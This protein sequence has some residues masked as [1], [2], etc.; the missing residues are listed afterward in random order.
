MAA[1]CR[2]GRLC[3]S[4]LEAWLRSVA[5]QSKKL[6]AYFKATSPIEAEPGDVLSDEDMQ[7][8][9]MDA[10]SRTSSLTS[11]Q[12]RQQWPQS[13]EPLAERHNDLPSSKSEH[14]GSF[15]DLS[16]LRIYGHEDIL[17]ALLDGAKGQGGAVARSHTTWC[18]THHAPSTEI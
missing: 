12:P 8:L 17:P 9:L 6:R 16:L 2:A 13:A 14:M 5:W 4:D 11:D 10:L 15:R 1:E 7:E 3:E 18:R